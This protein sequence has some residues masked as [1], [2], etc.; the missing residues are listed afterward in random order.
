MAGC[1][2]SRNIVAIN[3]DPDASI[4]LDA[5]FGIVGDWKDVLPPLKD[6]LQKLLK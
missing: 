2:G 1:A 3:K 5:R 6:A 4:F